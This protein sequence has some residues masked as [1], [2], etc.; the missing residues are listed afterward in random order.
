MIRMPRHVGFGTK[1]IILK[2]SK[3][4]YTCSDDS[5]QPL[6]IICIGSSIQ[7]LGDKELYTT[8]IESG[9]NI[10]MQISNQIGI[11]GVVDIDFGTKLFTLKVCRWTGTKLTL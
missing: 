11:F 10:Q 7:V 4:S 5:R 6:H 8:S 9:V 2:K 3:V 1:L